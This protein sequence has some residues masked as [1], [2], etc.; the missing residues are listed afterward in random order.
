MY[1]SVPGRVSRTVSSGSRVREGGSS[2]DEGGGVG[3]L[4]ASTIEALSTS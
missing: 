3:E 4:G 1:R 2:V